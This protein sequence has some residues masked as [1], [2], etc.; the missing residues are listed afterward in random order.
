MKEYVEQR[1]LDVAD[2]I[3]KTKATI[4]S[5]AKVFGV[6]KT[7]IHRDISERLIKVN[8][9]LAKEA[10]EVI[11]INKDERYVRGGMATRNKYLEVK[12]AHK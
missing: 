3:I 12:N 7:T 6:C 11:N 1:V 10:M 2:Y 4:R 8:P 5:T 9:Q